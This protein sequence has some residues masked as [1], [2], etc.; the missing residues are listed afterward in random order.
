MQWSNSTG[1]KYDSFKVFCVGLYICDRK[2]LR[3]LRIIEESITEMQKVYKFTF[4]ILN[5]FIMFTLDKEEDLPIFSNAVN[6]VL[7]KIKTY[8]IY[9]NIKLSPIDT[10]NLLENNSRKIKHINNMIR[11][12]GVI[13]YDCYKE[14]VFHVFAKNNY[15]ILSI[16]RLFNSFNIFDLNYKEEV[17]VDKYFDEEEDI[18]EEDDEYEEDE[19]DDIL[20]IT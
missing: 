10:I 15:N 18:E 3:Y 11:S 2:Y 6:S 9:K 7:E 12:I 8:N 1:V 4:C 20:V 16:I 14:G 5:G 13:Y 17:F 19:E